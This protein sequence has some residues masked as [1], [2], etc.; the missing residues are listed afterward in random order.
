MMDREWLVDALE[1]AEVLRIVPER[2]SRGR[3]KPRNFE[4]QR[5]VR[6]A[7]KFYE[8]WKGLNDADGINDHGLSEQMKDEALRIVL[9]F[10]G[11]GEVVVYEH[12][13]ERMGR[14]KD[15]R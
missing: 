4:Q 6:S 5:A 12:A 15:R 7:L 9:D 10:E 1:G 11:L 8:E 13:R 14:S 2:P 3:G